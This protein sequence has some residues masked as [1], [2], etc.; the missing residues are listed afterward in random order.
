MDVVAVV[1]VENKNI[2]GAFAANVWE[3]SSLVRVGVFDGLECCLDAVS[4]FVDCFWLEE[5]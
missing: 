3:C 4:T 5:V 1:V 2:L